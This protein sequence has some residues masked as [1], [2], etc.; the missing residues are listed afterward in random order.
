MATGVISDYES[1]ALTAELRARLF[2]FNN[3]R[4]FLG[5]ARFRWRGN[6]KDLFAPGRFP[7][8][9]ETGQHGVP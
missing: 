2:K 7:S 4:A 5:P 9:S 8:L 6:C 1:A 3:L